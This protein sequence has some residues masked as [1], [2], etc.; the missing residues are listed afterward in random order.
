MLKVCGVSFIRS[1]AIVVRLGTDSPLKTSI[2]VFTVVVHNVSTRLSIEVISGSVQRIK[3][4]II[5]DDTE[6]VWYGNP[7]CMGVFNRSY[8]QGIIRGY[9]CIEVNPLFRQS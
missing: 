9:N 1:E 3:R 5:A 6:L 7:F 4:I 8:C 2:S